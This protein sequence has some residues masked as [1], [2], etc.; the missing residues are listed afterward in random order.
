MYLRRNTVC[1]GL[2]TWVL[3]TEDSQ[4]AGMSILINCSRPSQSASLS[5]MFEESGRGFR[6]DDQGDAHM[7]T[8][9]LSSD[10]TGNPDVGYVQADG[11]LLLLLL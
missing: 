1:T 9:V 6:K 2:P 10:C 7:L 8:R 4:N 3:Q 5:I 11:L